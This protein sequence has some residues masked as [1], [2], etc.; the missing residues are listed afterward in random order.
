MTCFL[1]QTLFFFV[2]GSVCTTKRLLRHLFTT[3]SSA[4]RE[5]VDFW[6]IF[7]VMTLTIDALRLQRRLAISREQATT[8]ENLLGRLLLFM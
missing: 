5:C 4:E 6:P 8:M 2:K 7:V 1:L 3:I